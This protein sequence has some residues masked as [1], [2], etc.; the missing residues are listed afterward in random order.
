[1]KMKICLATLLCIL[2]TNSWAFSSTDLWLRA[3]QQGA[4]AL[5]AGNASL[6]ANLFKNTNWQAT[7]YYRAGDYAQAAK[8]FAKDKSAQGYYNLGNALAHQQDYHQAIKS[9]EKALK[10]QPQFADAKFNKELLEKLL[11]QQDP[12]KDS[13]QPKSQQNSSQNNSEQ[14]NNKKTPEQK[15]AANNKKTASDPVKREEHQAMKEWFRSID[16]DP[17]SFLKQK[18]ARD[19]QK[20]QQALEEGKALW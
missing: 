1:M 7:A 2:K 6:A 16:D 8:Y 15:S 5:E 4:R 14:N 12:A 11:K 20:Y 10:L 18:F 9:Y 17:G 13:K 19:H 3:D